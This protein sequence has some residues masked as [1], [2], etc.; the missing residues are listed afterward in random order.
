M[1]GKGLGNSIQNLFCGFVYVHFFYGLAALARRGSRIV[2]SGNPV[3]KI[4]PG[5]LRLR[6]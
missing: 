2:Y 6:W 1:I 3:A 5:R 4:V